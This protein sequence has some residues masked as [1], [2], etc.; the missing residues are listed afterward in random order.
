MREA[1]INAM[2]HRDYRKPGDL[3]V[4]IFQDRV[5][6]IN[7]GGLVGGMTIEKL[8]TV[9]L[10]RNPLL[11]GM[12]HRMG[13]VDQKSIGSGKSS[14]K[15][16]VLIL[17]RLSSMPSTTIPELATALDLSTRAIDMKNLWSTEAEFGGRF[18]DGNGVFSVKAGEAEVLIGNGGCLFRIVDGKIPQAVQAHKIPYFIHRLA[19]GNQLTLGGK[20][21]T[22][23]AGK[24]MG[25]ATHHHV[26][27]LGADLAKGL[28]PGSGRGAADDGILHDQHP[29]PFQQF[30]HRIQFHLDAEIPHG[31]GGLNK[32][33]PM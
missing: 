20:I 11:F 1:L 23:V 17:E 5:E 16:D 26:H 18:F 10:P 15:T 7:P 6:I 14:G 30:P 32:V 27:L 13:L 22:V 21:D 25:R 12:M 33:L 19:G 31:L 8:G 4:H 9:S 24:G 3:Q 28:H 2:A 29:F